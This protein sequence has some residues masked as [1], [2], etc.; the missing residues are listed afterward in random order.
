MRPYRPRRPH[1]CLGWSATAGRCT[2]R[3]MGTRRSP[4]WCDECD[5]AREAHQNA[6]MDR[7]AREM[8]E[9]VRRR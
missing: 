3:P 7:I 4:W 1:R 8:Q 6:Q 5:T 2:S 9:E